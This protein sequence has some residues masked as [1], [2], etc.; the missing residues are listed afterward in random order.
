[1]SWQF[2]A[3]VAVGSIITLVA[4]M[5][6]QSASKANALQ[7]LF[8]AEDKVKA[9][10]AARDAVIEAERKAKHDAIDQLTLEEMDA[11]FNGSSTLDDVM[12]SREERTLSKP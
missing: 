8:D 11:I 3:G 6:A 12:R 10:A 7:K 1:V 9:Q 5:I 2:W 4:I